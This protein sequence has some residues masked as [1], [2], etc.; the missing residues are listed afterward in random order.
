MITED[1]PVDPRFAHHPPS[2]QS[3]ADHHAFYRR[4][5]AELAADI[6]RTLPN[7]RERSVALTNLETVSFWVNA[8]I[9]RGQVGIAS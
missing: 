7:S 4:R 5:M 2:D 8:A 9:A 6:E 3:V 1:Q